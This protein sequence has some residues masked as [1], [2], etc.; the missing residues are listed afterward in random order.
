MFNENDTGLTEQIL[1]G[2]Q[3][4]YVH[5][6]NPHASACPLAMPQ[7]S[8]RKATG[9]LQGRRLVTGTDEALLCTS[10]Q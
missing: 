5:N 2:L 7:F 4:E 3:M 1:N 6:G 8:F 9:Q 10:E